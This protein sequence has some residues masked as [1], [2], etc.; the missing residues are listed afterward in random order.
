L[1]LRLIDRLI[2]LFFD[3]WFWVCL[4]VFFLPPLFL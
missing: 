1:L 4:I 2:L 3:F